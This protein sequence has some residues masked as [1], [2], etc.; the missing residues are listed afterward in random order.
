[1]AVPVFQDIMLPLL[2]LA[3]DGKERVLKD[4]VLVLGEHFRLTAAEMA[5]LLPSGKQSRFRNRVSWAKVYLCMAGLLQATKRSCFRITDR[6][7]GVLKDPPPRIDIA[8]LS[9]FPEFIR[10]RERHEQSEEPTATST[11]LADKSPE[12][13]IETAF[14]SMKHKLAAELLDQ[15]LRCSPAFF[16][17]LVV[18][19]L[20]AMGYGGSVQDAGQALVVG[21]S[22]DGG[23]DGIIK[24]DKLGLEAIYVQAKRWEGSVGRPQLQSFVG[25]M[26]GK[27]S[28]GVFITTSAF[29]KD[30]IEYART[31]GGTKVILIDGEKLAE[32]MIEH[33]V[34]VSA[35][36]T[37]VVKKVDYDYFS[38]E[39]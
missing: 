23:I 12:E 28:K 9:T 6:G 16:E 14:V 25:A 38:E 17:R 11:E 30:A 18:D 26:H 20:V 24:Q 35:K 39:E 31:L 1:M 5:E 37:Y 22:G 29:T 13:T 19:L 3:G 10:H 36:E 27:G 15:I 32:L 7:L 33:N 2:R 21:K 4:V 34:G 8:F